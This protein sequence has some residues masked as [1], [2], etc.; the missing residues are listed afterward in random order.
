[1]DTS[2]KMCGDDFI[3]FSDVVSAKI[4]LL[5]QFRTLDVDIALTTWYEKCLK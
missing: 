4:R 3:N 5:A 2:A 1:M